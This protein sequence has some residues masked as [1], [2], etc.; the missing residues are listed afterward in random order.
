MKVSLIDCT[1]MGTD[2]PSNYAASILIFTKSTRLEMKPGL[3]TE[4]KAWPWKKKE[5][6]LTYMANTIPSS[7]EFCHYT[8]MIEGVTRA[9]THQL[10]RTRTASFAQQ[11][12]R[13]LNVEGWKYGTGPTVADDHRRQGY[14]DNAMTVIDK[15][16]AELIKMGAKTEDARGILPTNIHTNIAMGANLRVLCEMIR[17][18]SS[19]RVQGEYRDFISLLKS[20]ILVIHPWADIFFAQNFDK[21]ADDLC[22]HLID[23]NGLNENQRTAMIK[24]VDQMRA[25]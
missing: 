24:L 22:S 13:V 10:V 1:G 7:W 12:M 8:F 20:Q 9:F 14:Y 16:Y 6:E 4:I 17:K 23:A 2:D 15:A 25:G 19:P 5:E 3:L 21:A 11:T 18:R